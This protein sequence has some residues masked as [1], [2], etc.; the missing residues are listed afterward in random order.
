VSNLAWLSSRPSVSARL[1][2]ATIVTIGGMTGS[3]AA[4]VG[5]GEP[6]APEPS[7]V[8]VPALAAGG[9]GLALATAGYWFV[10]FGI[11]TSCTDVHEGVH[12][13]DAMYSW[14]HVGRTVQ[15]ALVLPVIAALAVGL[16]WPAS[17]KV[18]AIS[19]WA[20]AVLAV[21]WFAFY[22]YSANSTF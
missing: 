16:A 19:T 17:R 5:Q 21:A 3:G 13:C 18:I 7:A 15:W 12:G 4:G 8:T 6:S 9:L 11:A 22:M 2:A 20:L 10:G 14:M 1:D